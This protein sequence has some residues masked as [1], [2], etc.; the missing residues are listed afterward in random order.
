MWCMV[1]AFLSKGCANMWN[2]YLTQTFISFYD[3]MNELVNYLR[4]LILG[5][6]SLLIKPKICFDYTQQRKKCSTNVSFI[7]EFSSNFDLKNM[8]STFTKGFSKKN[9]PNLLDFHN[10]FFKLLDFY[11]KF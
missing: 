7:G 1:E 6:F 3:I 11:D 10:F 2:T 8:I 5:T 4:I 9:G